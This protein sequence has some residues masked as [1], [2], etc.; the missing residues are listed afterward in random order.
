MSNKEE[1]NILRNEL[2]NSIET[3]EDYKIIYDLSVRLDKLIAL[4]Y[5]EE[6]MAKIKKNWFF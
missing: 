2:N 6:K 3:N 4:Y 1:I 5:K